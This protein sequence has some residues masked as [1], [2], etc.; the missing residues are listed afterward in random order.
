MP[1][2]EW[3]VLW[4]GRAATVEDPFHEA[5]AS[6]NIDF[7]VT[8]Y[9]SA[10]PHMMRYVCAKHVKCGLKLR[11]ILRGA[12]VEVQQTGKHSGVVR[13][14]KRQRHPPIVRKYIDRE[15]RKGVKP[16]NIKASLNS[17][18]HFYKDQVSSKQ[19]SEIKSGIREEVVNFGDLEQL[20]APY[21]I[22]DAMLT[23]IREEKNIDRGQVVYYGGT[24]G[25]EHFACMVGNAAML[26][27]LKWYLSE[28][29]NPKFALY[30]DCQNKLLRNKLQIMWLGSNRT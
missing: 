20:F 15:A 2:Y 1:S 16:S 7:P 27:S 13:D 21:K 28:S 10:L 22:D 29:E 3:E 26:T 8:K 19:I 9:G 4:K 12:E 5:I 18:F 30:Q 17:N 25:E 11:V 23:S 14:L 24:W 6:V